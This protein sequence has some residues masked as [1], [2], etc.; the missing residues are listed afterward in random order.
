MNGPL[1]WR[2]DAE[3]VAHPSSP[4]TAYLDVETSSDVAALA[5][6]ARADGVDPA[7]LEAIR[8]WVREHAADEALRPFR[9]RIVCW[10]VVGS[11]GTEAVDSDSDERALLGR[12]DEALA[13]ATRFV[14]FNGI[15][16]DFPF[17]RARALANGLSGLARRLWQ[18]KP[19]DGRLIDPSQPDWLPRDPRSTKGWT[20]D[21][22][23]EL[24][25]IERPATLPGSDVPLA[26]MEGRV[27]EIRAHC[28]DDVRTLREVTR[29]L[30]EGRAE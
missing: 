30:A 1:D 22:V 15:A 23:A 28:L 8:A 20:L 18:Q 16:F 6:A 27:E 12:L 21:A 9:G 10:A 17:V 7:D 19:W 24:L 14:A 4:W 29:A 5:Q 2:E 26:W 3:M 13:G 11:N 25:G